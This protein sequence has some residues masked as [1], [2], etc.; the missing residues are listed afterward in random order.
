MQV[1]VVT[2]IWI[3]Y[4]KSG[5][6]SEK[7][8]E[9][10]DDNRVLTNDIILAELIPFLMIRKQQKIVDLLTNI[11]LLTLKI[12]WTEII[13]WQVACLNAGINGIG[14]SDLIIAQNS[15][16]KRSSI[17]SLDKHFLSLNQVVD[18]SLFE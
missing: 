8:D 17:Y 12:D 11:P 14:I 4:F 10:L 15:K 2:S 7:L 1:L 16:Q 18:I 6:N 9:I 13:Q 5:L 3:D